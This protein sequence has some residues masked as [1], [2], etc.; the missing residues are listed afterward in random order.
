V[1]AERLQEEFDVEIDAWAFDLKPG[2]PPG[3]MP[4]DKAYSNLRIPPGYF[5][6]LQRIAADSGIRMLKPEIV[7]N[8]RKAHEATEFARDAGKVP[9]FQRALFDAYWEKGENI[10]AV[11]VLCNLA[12]GC[13]LDQDRLRQALDQGTHAQRVDE[14]MEWN[15]SVGITGVPT[16]IF[17]VAGGS[18]K[19]SLVGA[20]DYAV[21]RDV[22]SRVASG[23]L[24]S[25][26]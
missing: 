17:S 10:S 2:L 5:E 13:G 9:E 12:T 4:R 8:T 26:S 23:R 24:K 18:A 22:A 19:F 16:F 20:Q 21:F 1:R 15:R 6:N 7:A 14:Q 25:Q 3:G 11:D